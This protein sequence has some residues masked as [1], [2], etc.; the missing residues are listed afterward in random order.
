MHYDSAMA[1]TLNISVPH[2]LSQDEARARIGKA[3]ADARR[4]YGSKLSS[5][6]EK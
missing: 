6:E 4:T 3:I 1:K 5:V 2:N